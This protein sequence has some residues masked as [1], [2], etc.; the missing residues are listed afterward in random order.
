MRKISVIIV[1]CLA[2]MLTSCK[3]EN[4]KQIAVAEAGYTCLA[5]VIY[6]DLNIKSKLNVL[7]GGVFSVEVIEPKVLS[8]LRFEFEKDNM[9]VS[10][11]ELKYENPL[12]L[13]INGFAKI[14]N[15][16]F[17]RLVSGGTVAEKQGNEYVL[18]GFAEGMNY[19]L[20][21]NNQGLPLKLSVPKMD[22][23]ANFFDWN[24]NK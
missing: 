14:L 3:A 8:G 9:Q 2:I 20:T 22:L 24:Y 6:N 11:N 19:I 21:L 13:D 12:S 10:F 23:T 1:L 15:N 18:S 7:G 17:S 4:K 5:T 16:V